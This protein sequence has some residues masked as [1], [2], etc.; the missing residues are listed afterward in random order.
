M[1]NSRTWAAQII[2]TLTCLGMRRFVICTGGRSAP[3][4]KAIND[5]PLTTVTVCVDERSGAYYALGLT[6]AHNE[7]AVILTTSGSAVLNTIP[8]LC[9]ASMTNAP[10][11]LLSAD[12]PDFLRGMGEN[13]TIDQLSSLTSFLRY[14]KD[15]PIGQGSHDEKHMQHVISEITRHLRKGPCQLNVQLEREY[16][17]TKVEASSADVIDKR[18]L[19]TES[20]LS[21]E[22]LNEVHEALSSYEKGLIVVGEL[23]PSSD[24]DAI[25]DV[26]QMLGWPIV[27]DC[28][29]QLRGKSTSAM[30][31]YGELF[32]KTQNLADYFTPDIVLYLGGRVVEQTLFDWLTKRKVA[33][34][35]FI[36][37]REQYLN[38]KFCVA[39]RLD[40]APDAFCK[41]L[42][43]HLSH[44]VDSMWLAKWMEANFAFRSTVKK[45]I[46]NLDMND[47]SL[48]FDRLTQLTAIEQVF[49]GNSST[50]R[51]AHQLYYPKD[52]NCHVYSLRGHSGIDGNVSLVCGIAHASK[53]PIVGILGDLT[54]LY[55]LYGF[56]LMENLPVAI[57]VIN[58]R[59]SNLLSHLIKREDQAFNDQF[60]AAGHDYTFDHLAAL[61]NLK[62]ALATSCD[63]MEEALSSFAQDSKPVLIEWQT[64]SAPAGNFEEM[65]SNKS[66][67]PFNFFRK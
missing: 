15:L 25:L 40:L 27:A 19:P 65:L 17:L 49:F 23:P 56:S 59:G 33:N 54:A 10:L 42:K 43:P 9:E 66:K 31:S 5:H 39:S 35:W 52:T 4:A 24:G 30:L 32:F 18:V 57:V 60:I 48:L 63:D 47:E 7:P 53:A 6:K 1:T 58:N 13:Q 28:N 2:E 22:Q 11:L 8:A 26:A 61:F 16:H 64:K 21:E 45:E 62:Y 38:P 34:I 3:L 55:D 41:Q 46:Q 14:Q 50:I 20:R 37:D 12:R 51:F 67:A 29:S 44:R 36:N